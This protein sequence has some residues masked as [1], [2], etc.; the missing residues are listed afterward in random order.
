MIREQKKS[1]RKVMSSL[2]FRI[3]TYLK[4]KTKKTTLEKL[5]PQ[6]QLCCKFVTRIS[7][8]NFSSNF[9]CLRKLRKRKGHFSSSHCISCTPLFFFSFSP[10]SLNDKTECSFF[11]LS[12][13]RHFQLKRIVEGTNI[14]VSNKHNCENLDTHMH[15]LES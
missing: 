15:I 12:S 2:S 13:W 11:L 4:R 6:K 1:L 10:L 3:M 5:S 8:F 14:E 7:S 9:P